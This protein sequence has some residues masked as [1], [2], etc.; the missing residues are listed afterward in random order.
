MHGVIAR[1]DDFGKPAWIALMVLGF[2]VFWPVGLAILAYIIWSGRMG[3]GCGWHGRHGGDVEE[4]RQRA[5]DRVN[6]AA[7]HWERKRA[8]W[9]ERRQ[10]WGGPHGYRG[11]GMQETGNR[12]F[13]EY[14]AEA[15][16]KLEEEADEFRTFLERLRMARDRAEFDEYMKERRERGSS[17]PSGSTDG[18]QQTPPQS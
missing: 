9:E 7:A 15:L 17:G 2:I 6:R 4:W 5:I 1:I 8:R 14:R 13:D 18:S 12:A 3:I 10:R 16:R 11:G